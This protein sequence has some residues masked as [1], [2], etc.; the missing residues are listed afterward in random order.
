VDVQVLV[1]S[2]A[3]VASLFGSR[4]TPANDSA[5]CDAGERRIVVAETPVASHTAFGDAEELEYDVSFTRLHV[6][7]GRMRVAA[8]TLRGARVWR[9]TFSVDGGL[10]FLSVHDTNTSWFDPATFN[11]LRF[12]QQ[13]HEPRHNANRDFQIFP[14]QRLV[15]PVRGPEYASPADPID[16]VAIVY[17]VRTLA[18]EPGQCYELRRYFQPKGNPVVLH[19]VR[20]ERIE[21]PAGAFDAI[22]VRPEITTS[23][24]FSENGRAELW[25]SDNPAHVVLQLKTHLSF[26]SINL[27]LRRLSNVTGR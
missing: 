18:L 1:W 13:L 20:R 7:S 21:V 5:H 27:Y 4:V 6:G 12:A 9:A 14:E 10:P 26:G 24:I 25:L 3:A 15:K 16:E 11:S 22:V 17:Y 2:F 8:D 19:V 23:A